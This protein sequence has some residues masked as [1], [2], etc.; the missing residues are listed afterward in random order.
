MTGRNTPIDYD[1]YDYGGDNSS[2]SNVSYISD[3]SSIDTSLKSFY[4]G[5]IS[6]TITS[7]ENPKYPEPGSSIAVKKE[8]AKNLTI[9]D[10]LEYNGLESLKDTLYRFGAD[11]EGNVFT[12]YDTENHDKIV[13][14]FDSSTKLGDIYK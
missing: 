7:K 3:A 9:G 11:S 6:G 2:L 5:V 14:Y 1:S 8:A 4:A 10:A 13:F 12:I